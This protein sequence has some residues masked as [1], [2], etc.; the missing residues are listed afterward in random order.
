LPAAPHTI[1][2]PKALWDQY[3]VLAQRDQRNSTSEAVREGLRRDLAELEQQ[4][5]IGTAIERD[6]TPVEPDD[7]PASRD[8]ISR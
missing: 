3:A 7:P 5:A 2:V 1:R 8:W 4:L 6:P